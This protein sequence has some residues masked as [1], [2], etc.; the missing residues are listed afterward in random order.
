M[1]APTKTPTRIST[2]QPTNLPTPFPTTNPTSEPTNYPTK[3]PTDIPTPS[4]STFPTIKPTIDPTISPTFYPTKYPTSYPTHLPSSDPTSTPTSEPTNYPTKLPTYMPTLLPSAFP[5]NNP[6]TNPTNSPSFYPTKYPTSY[7]TYSPSSDPTPTP[8]SEPTNHPTKLPT[9]MPTLLP[10]AFPTNNPTTDPTNSPSFYPSKYPT[11]HPTSLPSSDPTSAPTTK[12]PTNIPTP[13]PYASPTKNPTIDPTNSPTLYPTT[14][15]D[16]VIIEEWTQ[17]R[18]NELCPKIVHHA[19]GVGLC[20]K[21]DHPDYQRRLEFALANQLY[22]SCDHKCLYDYDTYNTSM[23]HAF[24][25]TGKCYNVATGFFCIDERDE[26]EQSHTHAATLCETPDECVERIEWTEEV[27]ESN[28]PDGY[29]NGD[30]GWGTAK[31]CPDLVRQRNGFYERADVLYGASFN[32][33]LANRMFLSCSAKCLYDIENE[34][35]VYQ[36]KKDCWVMQTDWA[37]IRTHVSE[38]EWAMMYLRESI[39]AI[40]T[41]APVIVPCVEREQDWTV[42]IAD[43]ICP[44]DAMGVT[45]KGV[46]AIVCTGYDDFQYRLDHSLA[47]RAFLTC[48][49]WCVYDIYKKGYEAFI[50]NKAGTCYKPV[51]KGLCIWTKSHHREL[52]TDYIENILCE[53]TTPEPTEA[54]TCIAQREWSEDLMDNYCSVEDTRLTYKHYSNI[55]RA[56]VPCS[57]FEERAGDL[58]KSLAMRMYADCTSW[59]VYDY[60][61]NALLAWKWSNKNLCWNLLTWGSCHWDN[62]NRMNSTEWNEAKL[63][64][65]LMC[66]YAPTQSPTDCVPL[67]TWDADRAEQICPS[68]EDIEADK[69]FGVVV[70]DDINSVTKQARLEKSLASNFFDK[71]SAW[72]VYDYDTIMNNIKNDSDE[73]GGFIW[74]NTCWKWVTGYACFDTSFPEF[75]R[76][77]ERALNQCEV[78]N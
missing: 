71:C 50:W 41:P 7:P 26:M 3:L 27:A 22:S 72:C 51:T 68:L 24:K 15:S 36:W 16:C 10:S 76:V 52:M 78:Q 34:G 42:E 13:T 66:T 11:S 2:G 46:D 48:D 28:C 37:C 70:C 38:Y 69:S 20:K 47:N 77:S 44:A 55:S 60:S 39:C 17:A 61:S 6:T 33:S 73:Y 54:P 58:L 4:P 12:P 31:V 19:Y 45:K 32:R 49:S 74:K 21:Y 59:C 23:P 57:G 8:T 65:T 5:T 1:G 25:W 53:S 40:P 14:T 43:Q 30:K 18:A 9:Y 35:V 67:Y 64:M 75:T 29:S 63:A 56:A 62:S